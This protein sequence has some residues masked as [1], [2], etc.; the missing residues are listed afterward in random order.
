MVLG[1][2]LAALV[3]GVICWW[4]F[5][6]GP[7]PPH[8]WRTWN[9]KIFYCKESD[10]V[11][12]DMAKSIKKWFWDAGA[13]HAK[14]LALKDWGKEQRSIKYIE[15]GYEI[16]AETNEIGLARFLEAQLRGSMGGHRFRIRHITPER[17]TP[18][19]LSFFLCPGVT[20]RPKP[21]V[22]PGQILRYDQ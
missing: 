12:V 16:R 8:D 15:P 4:I 22:K 18:R 1:Y 6:R 11:T 10:P 17:T 21:G 19:S 14:D 5:W 3:A 9:F 20:K 2:L 13:P 7:V